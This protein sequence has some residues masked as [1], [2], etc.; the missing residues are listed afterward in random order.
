MKRKLRKRRQ[1]NK[2]V[3][4]NLD[5]VIYRNTTFTKTLYLRASDKVTPI[6]LTGLR[7]RLQIKSDYSQDCSI[8][9]YIIL[10]SNDSS[11]VVTPLIGKIVLTIPYTVT[12][13]F[14]FTGAVYDLLYEDTSVPP[15]VLPLLR[16]DVTLTPSSTG[17]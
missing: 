10:D 1:A 2:I 6:D 11:I 9:S 16:G 3:P 12:A 13:T 7:F 15:I 8:A 17:F 14:S 4:G 5:L